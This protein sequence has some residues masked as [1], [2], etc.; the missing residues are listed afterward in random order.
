MVNCREGIRSI[1]LCGK[2]VLIDK[3]NTAKAIIGV[4]A[5]IFYLFTIVLFNSPVPALVLF[6]GISVLVVLCSRPKRLLIALIVYSTIV[7]FLIDDLGFPS[8]ANYVCDALLL[9]TIFFALR[10]HTAGYVSHRGFQLL[11]FFVTFFWLVAT[12]SAVLNDIDP[13]L[14]AWAIRNTFRLFGIMYC[15]VRLFDKTDIYRILKLFVVLFWINVV[16]CTYQ[17]F[18]LGTDM[19]HTNGVFG[20]GSGGNAMMIVMMY[21]ITAVYL[22]GYS[23]NRVKLGQLL[24]MLAACCYLAAIAELKV[25]YVLLALL[26]ALCTFLN[27][28]TLKTFTV[29]AVALI[30]FFTGIRL[31]ETYNP[32]FTGFFSFEGI[33]KSNYEGGYGSNEGLNR[34]SAVETLDALFMGSTQK[35]LFGRGFGA[36]QYT[37]FFESDLYSAWGETLH[38]TWFTDA[39]IFLETGYV[40]LALYSL[41]FLVIAFSSLHVPKFSLEDKW[42]LRVCTAVAIFCVMLIV[43]NCSLTVDP[44]CY[45]IGV[46]LSFYYI[47]TA[48]NLNNE[49]QA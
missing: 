47:L 25:Y 30:A 48:R 37:Q 43:Y 15:C 10:N 24:L 27:S 1:I 2:T 14:Y 46:L 13:L 22:F 18:I 12:I 49:L 41:Q 36:G 45:F 34:L 31:L 7:K 5:F 16:V 8:I 39:A 40:G 17:Y 44:T 19:D 28:P 42:F 11:G 35:E 23:S 20:T 3:A 38:W 4:L 32:G 29:L 21:F 26:I 33:V 9:L 6:F